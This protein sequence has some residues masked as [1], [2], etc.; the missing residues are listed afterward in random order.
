MRW[1]IHDRTTTG[2]GLA[3]YQDAFA[4]ISSISQL[5]VGLVVCVSRSEYAALTALVCNASCM[6]V[7]LAF[8]LSDF[9]T[10]DK[11]F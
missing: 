4:H 3:R 7:F 11:E 5:K 8:K 10:G 9:C 2:K 6:S 1:R